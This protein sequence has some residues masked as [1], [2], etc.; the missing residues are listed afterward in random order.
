MRPYT[1]A[2]LENHPREWVWSSVMARPRVSD[3]VNI[4]TVRDVARQWSR[5][6]HS[7]GPGTQRYSL[8]T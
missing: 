6:R 3:P 5:F 1:P 4:S 2:G 7:S 8:K